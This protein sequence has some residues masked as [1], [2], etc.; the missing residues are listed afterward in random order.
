MLRAP[1][2]ST[3]T[4]HARRDITSR[5]NCADEKFLL[6]RLMRGVTSQVLGEN[7]MKKFLLTRLMRGVT[8][9]TPKSKPSWSIST[10]TPHARRDSS[11]KMRYA[12][13]SC[14]STHTPHARRD[15]SL[16]LDIQ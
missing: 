5:K 16:P 4:P 10:H 15:L 7:I 9:T 1:L 3:H 12:K 6:T 13:G 2:I 11:E 8:P 14:I